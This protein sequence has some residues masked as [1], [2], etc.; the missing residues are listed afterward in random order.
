MAHSEGGVKLAGQCEV[1]LPFFDSFALPSTFFAFFR[2][3]S[4]LIRII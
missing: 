2:L 4:A 1:S 3:F